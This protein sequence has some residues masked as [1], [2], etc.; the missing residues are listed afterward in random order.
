MN[1]AE[2]K[3]DATMEQKVPE[4]MKRGIQYP[5]EGWKKGNS[6]CWAFAL[7][8]ENSCY[9]KPQFI[10]LPRNPQI[11]SSRPFSPP[12]LALKGLLANP[13]TLLFTTDQQA[14]RM[15]CHSSAER[16]TPACTHR[17][18]RWNSR[19]ATWQLKRGRLA[20]FWGNTAGCYASW[21]GLWR[22]WPVSRP[23]NQD[24]FQCTPP[25]KGCSRAALLQLRFQAQFSITKVK[26][27]ELKLTG[28][29]QSEVFFFN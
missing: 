23:Y 25:K 8:R 6:P 13:L 18:C 26:R 29:L 15:P 3:R 9:P 16:R 10:P 20:S 22:W 27:F 21:S 1:E 7:S 11:P 2:V 28:W 4:R 24:A 12:S 5:A 17:H 14:M 19:N